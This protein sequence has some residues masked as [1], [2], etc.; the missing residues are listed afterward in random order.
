MRAVLW[1]DDAIV[2]G[3]VAE[4][5]G[6]GEL[7]RVRAAGICGTDVNLAGSG[8]PVIPGHEVAGTL[9]DGTPVAI[10][11]IHACER[12]DQC[13][14]GY[15][16]RCRTGSGI[17]FGTGRDGGMAELLRVP[18]RALVL[19]PDGLDVADA[20]LVEPLAVALHGLR[21]AGVV[22]H[23]RVGFI[24]GGTIGL[25]AAAIAS[26]QGCDVA[27]AA[28]HARQRTAA[29]GLGARTLLDGEYDVVVE[30]AGTESAI[31][32]AVDA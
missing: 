1:R 5:Q 28:R 15:H 24:G 22:A 13:R 16:S 23:Q 9:R 18:A 21:G 29:E 14:A 27:I 2:V 10:E 3:E 32:S 7:V 6:D 26:R 25:C 19:L 11:P 30:A 8:F 17:F 20:C 12:C 31:A 4:P